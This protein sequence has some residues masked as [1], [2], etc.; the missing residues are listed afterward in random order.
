MNTQFKPA[1][2]TDKKKKPAYIA[3][4]LKGLGLIKVKSAKV[5]S[6]EYDYG[7]KK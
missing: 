4:R 6:A 1:T 7:F 5:F 2:K 3:N